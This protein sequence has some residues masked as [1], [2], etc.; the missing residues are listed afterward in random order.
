MLSGLPS[1]L[2]VHDCANVQGIQAVHGDLHVTLMDDPLWASR[3]ASSHADACLRPQHPGEGCTWLALRRPEQTASQQCATC[4]ARMPLPQAACPEGTAPALAGPAGMPRQHC[5]A[6]HS[7]HISSL[8]SQC[9]CVTLSACVITLI[10]SLM[11][12]DC[13]LTLPS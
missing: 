7:L 5:L 11:K 12:N 9:S 4:A 10:L 6:V 13:T 3:H 2:K 8:Q 1:T